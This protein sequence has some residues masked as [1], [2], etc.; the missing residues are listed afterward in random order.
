MAQAQT[1]TVDQAGWIGN[2]TRG[3]RASLQ[4]RAARRDTQRQM[5][6]R[7]GI[8]RHKAT[9]NARYNAQPKPCTHKNCH[10][11]LFSVT[12]RATSKRVHR[13]GGANRTEIAMP[14]WT[15][16]VDKGVPAPVDLDVGLQSAGVFSIT[17][18]DMDALGEPSHVVLLFDEDERLVGLRPAGADTPHAYPVRKASS[19]RTYLVSA[20]SFCRRYGL[21]GQRARFKARMYDNVLGFHVGSAASTSDQADAVAAAG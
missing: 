4:P 3:F 9:H 8:G 19:T 12:I 5:A 7:G 13:D 11:S 1:R 15:E 2:A 10:S 20:A 17:K 21:L 14:K 6:I 18:A 16:Y